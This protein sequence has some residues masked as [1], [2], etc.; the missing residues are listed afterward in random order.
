MVG[1]GAGGDGVAVPLARLR[2]ERAVT[3]DVDG[4]AV[5][6]VWT[7][8]QASAL[9][10]GRVD[11]GVD[12]GQTG[13]FA[14]AALEPTGDGLFRDPATGALHD[15]TGAVVEGDA[16]ELELVALDDTFW[17]VWFAFRPDTE[18]AAD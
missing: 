4:E 16:D 7:P 5:T 6:L 1:L 2:D 11:E 3:V 14:I 13:A 18:I 8:G 17:F 12:V 15:V 9:D 10:G